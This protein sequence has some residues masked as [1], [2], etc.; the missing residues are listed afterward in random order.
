M[1]KD[2]LK[3]ER[4]KIIDLLAKGVINADEAEKLLAALDISEPRAEIIIPAAK[5]APFR[6]LK[7]YVDS[8]DGDKIRVQIPIEFAKLL[9]SGKLIK[10]GNTNMN[11]GDMDIDVDQVIELINSG[12][13]GQIVDI[14]TS[15]G[16]IVKI[17]VE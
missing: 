6:M 5:K 13:V 12:A 1:A 3:E 4:L 9:K 2:R 14:E 15:N 17:V 11:L 8:S 10:S 16:D 7:I